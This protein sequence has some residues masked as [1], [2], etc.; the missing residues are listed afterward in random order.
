[1]TTRPPKPTTENP[2]V[3]WHGD[4]LDVLPVLP[5]GKFDCVITDP[6][7]PEIDR[8]YGRWTEAEWVELMD[9]VVSQCRR[10]LKSSGSAVFVLQPNSERVGRI[11]PWLFD[12]QAKWSRSWNMVQD[13]WWHNHQ[14]MPTIHCR[15]D[16][17]LARPSLKACVW[18][19]AEDCYRDQN[20]VLVEPAEST[21]KDKRATDTRLKYS[22]SSHHVR[23]SN[24]IGTCVERGGS[25]P[26]NVLT[27]GRGGG[28]DHGAAT[29]IRLMQWWVKY[30]CPPG[31][32]ILDPFGGSGTTAVA[33]IQE[34]RRC[35]L[36][37]KD[38]AYCEIARKRV[39][40][41]LEAR[42]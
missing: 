18:L 38:E 10:V 20:A 27:F 12:F 34:G 31:G 41:V 35:L 32:L 16:Y 24:S 4:C 1:M 40:A 30:I 42:K 7:Y 9:V 11:R 13:I 28:D 22:D 17:G 36:I 37:E 23:H 19:G 14:A 26:F 39:A 6:P 5:D 21:K 8:P 2:A 15:R 25:T 33:A 3:V 29:P